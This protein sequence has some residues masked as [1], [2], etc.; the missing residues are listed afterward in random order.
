LRIKAIKPSGVLELQGANE[1]TIG[2]HSKI[3]APCHL[4]NLDPTIITSTWIP[5]L[6]YPCEV[7][8]RTDNVD[9]MILC[10]N[11]NGGYHLLCLKPKLTQ[12]PTGIWYYSSCSLASPWFLLEPCHTFP[13]SSLGGIH[14]NF[15]LTSS[16]A[17][18][19]YMHAFLFG[20]LISTFDWFLSFCLVKF[21][22]DLHPYDTVRHDS[23]HAPMH[24]LMHDGQLRACP[25]C[26]LGLMYISRVIVRYWV[27]IHY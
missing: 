18:Y 25:S 23:C 8:Q 19:I 15:I 4:L 2:D 11:C 13:G 22:M 14:E 6:D 20:W 7:C 5:P 10:N 24:G 21:T 26:L 16:C 3:C 27:T 9:Q 1:C 12:V 17:F